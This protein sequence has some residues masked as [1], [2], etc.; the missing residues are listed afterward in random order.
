MTLADVPFVSF[1]RYPRVS[2]RRECNPGLLIF[3]PFR[4]YTIVVH[5]IDTLSPFFSQCR[6]KGL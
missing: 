5:H 2:E 6:L 4:I 3:N 1:H